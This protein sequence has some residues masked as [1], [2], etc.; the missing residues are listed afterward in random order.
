M[1]MNEI[2]ISSGD[3]LAFITAIAVSFTLGVIYKLR[4]NVLRQR[5]AVELGERDIKA[6]TDRCDR[7]QVS[8]TRLDQEVMDMRQAML[9]QA[10]A[11]LPVRNV[12]HAPATAVAPTQ[13]PLVATTQVPE[14]V[15]SR[16]T[17]ALRRQIDESRPASTRPVTRTA[18][19]KPPVR[20]AASANRQLRSTPAPKPAPINP[21][22]LARTGAKAEVLMSRCGLSRAEADLVLLV[23]GAAA[24][25]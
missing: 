10:L 1:T 14:R 19:A 23:H 6:L 16:T 13:A 7:Q 2:T 21:V 17:A 11:L 4:R 24:R 18:S 22:Q 3:L 20:S 5:R 15:A 9:Q 25:A 8:M 12:M